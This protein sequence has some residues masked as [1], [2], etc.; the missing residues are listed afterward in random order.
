MVKWTFL[1]SRIYPE[2]NIKPF[3][4]WNR[5]FWA[6]IRCAKL[7]FC[8]VLSYQS[9]CGRRQLILCY[10][11]PRWDLAYYNKGSAWFMV[12]K[13]FYAYIISRRWRATQWK[14]TLERYFLGKTKP[15][16]QNSAIFEHFQKWPEN[17]GAPL[18][19][20]LQLVSSGPLVLTNVQIPNWNFHQSVASWLR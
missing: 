4:S 20:A 16:C 17:Q 5:R 1:R 3:S 7:T 2:I 15:T 10:N 6:R 13:A 8:G 18:P 14:N 11:N 9:P 12:F 19:T